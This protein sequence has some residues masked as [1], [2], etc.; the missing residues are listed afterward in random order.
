MKLFTTSFFI[1]VSFS[2]WGQEIIP[3]WPEGIPNQ[4]PSEEKEHIVSSDIVRIDNVQTP[5]L[6]VYLPSKAN[7]TGKAVIICPG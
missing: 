5:T 2:L 1:L 3:L 6:E 4:N 7:H